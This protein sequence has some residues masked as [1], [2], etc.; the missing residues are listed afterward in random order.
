[1]AGSKSE[2]DEG[3][4]EQLS[5]EGLTP[6]QEHVAR[7]LIE[8]GSFA[9]A[10][11]DKRGRP[12]TI[13]RFGAKNPSKE[14]IAACFPDLKKIPDGYRFTACL[15]YD[16][17]QE[18]IDN[19]RRLWQ[20]FKEVYVLMDTEIGNIDKLRAEGVLVHTAF[21]L[22]QISALHSRMAQESAGSIKAYLATCRLQG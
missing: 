16:D 7:M 18:T 11:P 3:Q 4:H 12:F 6:A 21:N 9:L 1:M 2:R 17:N 15:L 20:S 5:P 8:G 14:E 22:S 19:S 10:T 13:N